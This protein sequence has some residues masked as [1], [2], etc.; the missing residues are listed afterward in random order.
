MNNILK[1]HIWQLWNVC[2][3]ESQA[4]G[5]LQETADGTILTC[6]S[7]CLTKTETSNENG[8]YVR[9]DILRNTTK[10]P[11]TFQTLR[12]RFVF[13]GGEYEVYTQYNGWQNESQGQ[14][15]PLVT[16]ISARCESVRSAAGA[17]GL[18]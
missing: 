6:P 18:E 4:E 8:I 13:D 5:S 11:L 16:E 2:T 1:D 7:Y 17:K 10:E 14:W 12:S 3:T 15:S 9:K